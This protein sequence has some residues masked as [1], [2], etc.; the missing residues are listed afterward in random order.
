MYIEKKIK[1]RDINYYVRVE[2]EYRKNENNKFELKL[3]L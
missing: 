3:K 1:L 2:L